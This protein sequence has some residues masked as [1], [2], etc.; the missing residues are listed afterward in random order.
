M[1]VRIKPFGHLAGRGGFAASG[2]RIVGLERNRSSVVFE[3]FGDE[4]KHHGSV[5]YLIIIGKVTDRDPINPFILL[6]LPMLAAD[7]GQLPVKLR[8]L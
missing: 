7:F 2:H 1:V 4:P 3:T 8:L 6:Q 5:Q